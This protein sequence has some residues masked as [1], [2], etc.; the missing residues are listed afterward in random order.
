MWMKK[1]NDIVRLSGSIF[2]NKK[3]KKKTYQFSKRKY[4]VFVHTQIS[5]KKCN[6][7]SRRV[8]GD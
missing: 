3:N 7:L 8:L 4:I 2:K 6:Q 1:L 5:E